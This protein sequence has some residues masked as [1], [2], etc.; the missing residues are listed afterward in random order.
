MHNPARASLPIT[1][2][3]PQAHEQHMHVVPTSRREVVANPRSSVSSVVSGVPVTTTTYKVTADPLVRTARG[4]SRSRSSTVDSNN[5]PTVATSAPRIQHRPVI[6]S[7]TGGRPSSPLFKNPYRSSEEEYYSV[8]ATSKHGHHHHHKRYSSTTNDADMHRSAKERDSGRQWTGATREERGY[9]GTRP[10]YANSAVRHPDNVAA[11]YGDNGFGYTNPRDLV[12]YDLNNSPAPRY[13]T[14]RDS[15]ESGRAQRPTS[16]SSYQDL[17]N[18]R[19]P[20]DTRERGPPP[21]TRGF[22]KIQ[23]RSGAREQ[24]PPPRMPV[25]PPPPMEPIQRPAR[26]ESPFEV[27]PPRRRESLTRRHERPVSLYHNEPKRESQREGYYESNDARRER[28]YRHDRRDDTVEKRGSGTRSER[29][30]RVERG[31]RVNRERSERSPDDWDRK[32]HKEHKGSKDALAAGL[33]I[34]GAALGV[35]TLKKVRSNDDRDDREEREERRKRLHDDEYDDEPRRRHETKDGRESLDLSNRDPRERRPRD[36]DMPPPPPPGPPLGYDRD[37]KPEPPIIDLSGRDPQERPSSRGERSRDE[38]PRDDRPREQRP[39]KLR[40]ERERDSDSDSRERDRARRHHPEVGLAAAAIAGSA[41]DSREESSASDDARPHRRQHQTHSRHGSTTVPAPFNPK[42]TMDLKALKEA[43]NRNEASAPKEP[44]SAQR[45]TRESV[46]KDARELADVRTDLNSTNPRG[47]EPSVAP[48]KENRQL[49]VVSPPR[50]KPED[51]P[52]KSI[53]R[54]PREKFPEDPSPIREGVAPLKDAKKDGVPPDARWTKIS[55]KLV[56]PAALEAG[57]ERF[58]EREDFVI[59]L[60]VLS[61][62]EVQGYAEVT[63]RIRTLRE[64]SER[65]DRRRARRDRHERHKKERTDR[66]DREPSR[67]ERSE[68]RHR[69]NRD[70]EASDNESDTTD[71]SF[72]EGDRDRDRPKMIEPAKPVMSGGLGELSGVGNNFREDPNAPGQYIGYTRNPPQPGTSVS[73]TAGGSGKREK[74]SF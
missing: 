42:D 31:D 58:E 54:A 11:D 20:Y 4:S 52:V 35:N 8:P 33:S 1:V 6:H 41:I 69:R 9:T 23:P 44:V 39:R 64:E 18:P 14:R 47:R 29:S 71:D 56:N 50:E 70:R 68:R 21:S 27:E 28:P 37:F 10:D 57:K 74:T 3:A 22:D 65:Q 59:V 40:K 15:F 17:A 61:R 45:T 72:Y 12:Q 66:G 24:P 53:L 32:E 63:E 7:A 38:R 51:K 34:A 46:S 25:A 67:N 55:R 49:R 30:D 60:R 62:D 26:V 43:L 13:H 19:V 16:L 73:S 48:N 2:Y 36:S 5:R